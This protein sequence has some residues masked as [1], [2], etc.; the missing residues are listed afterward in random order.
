MQH[1]VCNCTLPRRWAIA[2][3]A[4]GTT[5]ELKLLCL[6]LPYCFLKITGARPGTGTAIAPRPFW[7][8]VGYK[9]LQC[10]TGVKSSP[11]GAINPRGDRKLC[12]SPGPAK[13]EESHSS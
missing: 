10:V 8:A 12:Y 3:I 6:S 9:N 4:R 11:D 5:C 2:P 1:L 13:P 7:A